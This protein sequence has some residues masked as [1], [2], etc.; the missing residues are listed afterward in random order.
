M[1]KIIGHRGARNLWPENSLAGFRNT[2]ELGIDG[3][4]FDVHQ[5]KDGGLVVIHDPTLERTTL[6][7][8]AI[9]GLTLDQ[10]RAIRL[11]DSEETIPALDQVLDILQPSSVEL[12]IEIKTD[13]L[14]RSYEGLERRLVELVK[15]RGLE[16]R[17]IL[18]CF[19]APVLETIRKLWPEARVLASIDRRSA[20][21]H[22]GIEPCLDRFLAIAGCHIAVEKALLELAM[23]LCLDRIGTD[24][25]AAWVPNEPEEIRYWLGQPIRAIT[26]DRP[27]L[28]L[29]GR[30]S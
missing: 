11:R 25:L 9:G 14:G 29:A 13:A 26:T 19:A 17:A 23:P 6:G 1:V 24:R 2:L 18:T 4:E 27:D 15:R 30:R 3:V 10:S 12:H 8:G 28:A 20:E 21:A 16:E 5:T 7:K 22:G